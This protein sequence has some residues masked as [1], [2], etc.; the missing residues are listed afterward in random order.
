MASRRV[1]IKGIANIPQRKKADEK[2]LSTP[3]QID[4]VKEEAVLKK[5]NSDGTVHFSDSEENSKIV[6]S[7]LDIIE[8]E[9]CKD[10]HDSLEKKAL[11]EEKKPIIKEVIKPGTFIRRTIA[12]PIIKPN[13]IS[14][15]QQ[16]KVID[17]TEEIKNNHVGETKLEII[18]SHS[19]Q[20]NA[21]EHSDST[22]NKANLIPK[23]DENSNKSSSENFL[24]P[25]SDINL[26]SSKAKIHNRKD[27]SDSDLETDVGAIKDVIVDKNLKYGNSS[28]EYILP[29][30]IAG[31]KRMRN[32]LSE[33]A[34]SGS[35][36][37]YP[38][39]P[40]SPNKILSR[41]RIKAVPCL[42]GR[43]ISF[44]VYGSASESEDEGKNNSKRIRNDSV[45]SVMS[46]TGEVQTKGEQPPSS[47]K[48][49]NEVTTTPVQKKGRR[50]DQYRKFAEARREFNMKFGKGKPDR[51]KLTMLDLI[52]YNPATNP[53]SQ[54]K[55]KKNDTT[56]ETVTQEDISAENSV[57][58][59]SEKIEDPVE[60]E[61]NKE[62]KSD[63]E[64]DVLAPQIKVGPNG[65]IIVDEKS[66]VVENK[67][68]RINR[69]TLQNS[70]VIDG[71]F[72]TGFNGYKKNARAKFWS[73]SETLRFY[74]ALNTIGTDFSLMAELFPGRTRKGLKM[75]FNKEERTNP[76]LIDR[77]LTCPIE[78]DM[79]SLR[80]DLLREQKEKEEMMKRQ[81]ALEVQS[82]EK[83][84]YTRK[85]G[86]SVAKNLDSDS[87]KPAAKLT[88]L[89]AKKKDPY[90][91]VKKGIA[92]VWETD[93][94]DEKTK[95]P[96]SDSS[97][98]YSDSE[99]SF[100]I[101]DENNFKQILIP[102]RSGRIPR[103]ALR[104]S[105]PES[106][107]KTI[108]RKV[109]D[110]PMDQRNFDFSQFEPGSLLVL[111]SND[112][113]GLPVYKV[114]MVVNQDAHPVDLSEEVLQ[115]IANEA[116][117]S[118]SS[119]L[120][121]NVPKVSEETDHLETEKSVSLNAHFNQQAEEMEVSLSLKDSDCTNLTANISSTV[122]QE[123]KFVL[124]VNMSELHD[125]NLTISHTE[126]INLKKT[127]APEYVR[128]EI[129]GNICD[130][131]QKDETAR[132]KEKGK[133]LIKE[134]ILIS[135]PYMQIQP[136]NKAEES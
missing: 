108:V 14:R 31:F 12:K 101:E 99:R 94:E 124:P 56:E 17:K 30:N 35:D 59:N 107:G 10:R 46:Y 15:R 28:N 39:P 106:Y 66:L 24:K 112:P 122:Y 128:E 63:D 58:T 8:E 119:T 118:E 132:S 65:E 45:S 48:K 68:T 44:S 83:R 49:P 32:S 115:S 134:N 11:L 13:N 18:A 104:L 136:V 4:I 126:E 74:K 60:N 103:P 91:C 90:T 5:D 100:T 69:E 21:K 117:H 67:E 129:I 6:T 79:T 20:N 96:E 77:A 85:K 33:S 113:T 80:L 42:T 50:S 23:S 27:E 41:S 97:P 130:S 62:V 125:T 84:R 55:E 25:A 114:F 43:R 64:D 110:C 82:K 53:M 75:K 95:M 89:C 38:L 1:R 86:G 121:E 78:F 22:Q 88:K 87:L 127:A 70:A 54:K 3:E 37:E 34:K 47:P 57:N 51:Q 133:I 40:A 19:E 29:D 73:K 16:Y 93:S 111:T 81:E 72:D 131:V 102:T 52:F 92:S 26:I 116:Q 36:V 109:P 7:D 9:K 120:D 135:A 105:Y 2:P 76:S 98:E 71:D 123:H 61:L